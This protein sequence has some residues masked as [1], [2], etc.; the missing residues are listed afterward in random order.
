MLA[1]RGVIPVY[2]WLA[3]GC[4]LLFVIDWLVLRKFVRSLPLPA[5][6]PRSVRLVLPVLYSLMGIVT[7]IAFVRNPTPSR[8]LQLAWGVVVISGIWYFVYRI[9]QAAKGQIPK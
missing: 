3:F 1:A 5:P 4:L 8:S 9:R 2:P 7:L 6:R